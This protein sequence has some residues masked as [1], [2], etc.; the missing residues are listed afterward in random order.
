MS[1]FDWPGLMRAG[2]CGLQLRPAEFWNLTPGELRIMLGAEAASPPFT[3]ARLEE[4]SRAF[5][6]R[7]PRM[8]KEPEHGGY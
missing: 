6:D 2:L 3:R 8:G 4:L 5:P 7:G 1:G